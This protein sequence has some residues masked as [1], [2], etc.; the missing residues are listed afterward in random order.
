MQTLRTVTTGLGRVVLETRGS[1]SEAIATSLQK[2]RDREVNV[3]KDP[4]DPLTLRLYRSPRFGKSRPAY[5]L[6]VRN[7]LS[8]TSQP[9]QILLYERY[10]R[11][12]AAL[13]ILAV[14]LFS[15]S[16]IALPVRL[17]SGPDIQGSDVVFAIL[18]FASIWIAHSALRDFAGEKAALLAIV[19]EIA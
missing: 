10:V 7:A 3:E 19:S 6:I 12:F 5:T 14:I 17:F 2:A 15:I 13:K 11:L 16:I 4:V 1:R 9:V 8:K 18:S